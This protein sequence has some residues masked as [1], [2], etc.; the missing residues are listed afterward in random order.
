MPTTIGSSYHAVPRLQY[1]MV[2]PGGMISLRPLSSSHGS[3]PPSISNSNSTTSS[4]IS[5]NSGAQIEG[6]PGANLFIYHIPQEFGDQELANAF[7]RI[8][9][10]VSVKV[11]VDKATGAS[12]CFV[13][14]LQQQ[15][16]TFRS[17]VTFQGGGDA[18][19]RFKSNRQDEG[20]VAW[21]AKQMLKILWIFSFKEGLIRQVVFT[22][23]VEVVP[24]VVQEVMIILF[25]W[26]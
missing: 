23:F 19:L 6:P 14:T 8:G 1:P 2:F 5:T 15:L 7:Q 11:F 22:G 10:V 13:T 25:L 20:P 21:K 26:L 12:K 4:S 18:L 24:D 3:M 9:R 17:A 16:N